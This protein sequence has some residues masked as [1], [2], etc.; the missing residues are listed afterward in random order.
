MK[1]ILI[2]ITFLG[3]SCVTQAQKGKPNQNNKT[4]TEIQ[5]RLALK[6]L[7][8]NFSILADQKK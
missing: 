4:M 7:V 2:V 6:E 1:S 8:D 5:D 3:F